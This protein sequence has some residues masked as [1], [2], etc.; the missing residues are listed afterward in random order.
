MIIDSH[1]HYS[2][3]K[4]E[5]E[6]SY[7]GYKDGEYYSSICKRDELFD[8]MKAAGIGLF[9]EPAIDLH[10]NYLILDLCKRY[11]GYIYP[12]VGIHPTRTFKVSFKMR[13]E[14]SR[15]AEENQIVAIGETGLD[16]H[17]ERKEQ[18][19]LR[20]YFWFIY[21]IKLADRLKLP[22]VLHVRM[23][24]KHAL[25]ILN[26]YKDRL[27]GGVVHCFNGD[28]DTAME[29][30]NLGFHIGIGGSLLQNNERTEG[31]CEAVANMPEDRILIE[32]DS[33][34]VLPD[35]GE[36]FTKK[37]LRK[38]T[39]TSLILPAVIKRIAELRNQTP[40]YIEALT[41]KNTRLLFGI[42]QV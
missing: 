41:E 18:H 25:K 33:P 39:N 6:F 20:Q 30:I 3:Y 11:P 19:R 36:R 28:L 1:A 34:Y 40:E 29:Y 17:Y 23:A 15:I 27:H 31:L 42:N 7:L 38:L 5:S 8:M 26:H 24:D 21:Q 35:M 37:K 14:L 9:I 22:L 32:T 16:Y 10:S 13:K 4:F 2:Y 12:S